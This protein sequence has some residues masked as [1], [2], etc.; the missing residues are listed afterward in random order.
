MPVFVN[1]WETGLPLFA[2]ERLNESSP[3]ASIPLGHSAE[4]EPFVVSQVV[5]VWPAAV[6]P[7][8][9]HTTA[10]PLTVA[11]WVNG[12]NSHAASLLMHAVPS[13]LMATCGPEGGGV[14]GGL[15]MM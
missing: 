6:V 14:G 2:M 7:A 5:T 11:F 10:G 13:S 9:V 1:T 12:V 8:L 15:V 4:V 3:V